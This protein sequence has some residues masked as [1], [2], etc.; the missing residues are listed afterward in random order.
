MEPTIIG[1]RLASAAV[2]PLIK[3]L[4]VAE[5]PGAGLVDKPIRISGYVSFNGEKRVLTKTDVRHLAA[6]LVEQALRSGESPIRADEQPAVTD[7]LATTLQALGELTITDLDAVR[8]GH[9]E[10]ARELRRASDNPERHL[11]ADGAYFY[12]TLLSTACLHILHFFTQRS[13]FVAHTL[14]QQ[15]RAVD[16]LIGKMDELIRRNPLPGGEDAAFEQGYLEYVAKK[17]GKLTI[18]GIDLNNSPTRWSLDVAYLSLEASPLYG[19]WRSDARLRTL[20]QHGTLQDGVAGFRLSGSANRAIR[21]AAEREISWSAGMDHDEEAWSRIAQ[22][23]VELSESSSEHWATRNSLNLIIHRDAAAV[24]GILNLLAPQAADQALATHPR[25]LLRG[26]AGSGKTTLIQWL[27]VTTA[28]QDLPDRKEYLYDRVP[29]V[30]PLRTLTR[31]GER[32]PGPRDFLSATGCPLAGS[33]PD[34]WEHRVLVAGRGLVLID[35]ID[36]IPERERERTRRWLQ[37]LIETYDGDNR[38]LVTSRPSAVDQGWLDEDDFAELTL[39]A[40]GPADI[41]T[42]IKRWHDAARASAD[43][44][45]DL[46]KYEAQL[47]TAVRTEPDLGRLAINP[48]M[49]GLICALHRDRRGYLPHGRKDLY[50]AALSMLLSRRDRERDM[51]G[52]E[53]ADD[54]QLDVLQRLAYWLI[55]NGRN[56]MDRSRAEDIIGRAL[57]AVPEMA[58]LGDAST[59]FEH[60][61]QRSGLLR[62]PAPDSVEFIHRTFQDFLGARAALEEGDF[63]LLVEH[64]ANDQW[65]D[66]IRMAVALARGRE[67]VTIFQDLLDRGD[68]AEDNRVQARIYL[69]AAAC[70]GHATSLLPAVRQEVEQ[71]TATLIPPGNEEEARALADVGPLILNLLPG[72][73]E[74]SDDVAAFHVVIAASHIKADAAIDFLARFVE[75]PSLPV[76][77]Q[78]LWA[79]PRFETAEYAERVIARL[80]PSNLTYTVQSD[81]QL[82]Q[83]NR[84]GLR[85]EGLDVRAGVSPEALASYVSRHG[86]A[87]LVLSNGATSDLGFLSGRTE[88]RSLIISGC[89]ALMDLSAIRGLPI[90]HFDVTSTRPDMDLSP[91][92]EL[93]DLKSLVLSGP[94]G[95]K[96]APQA[97]PVRAPLNSL[98]VS[99]GASPTRG[100]KGL[101]DSSLLMSLTLNPLSSPASA[102]D[103]EEISR[104]SH[105]TDFSTIAASFETLP[106]ATVLESVSNLSLAGGGGERVIQAAVNRLP[107]TFPGLIYCEFTGDMTAEGDIDVTPL[108]KLPYLQSLYIAIGS[109]RIRGA[110]ALP[111]SVDLRLL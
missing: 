62:E 111:S 76:R 17:H 43:D 8:L 12:E 77:S 52:P 55:K 49:C 11:T 80:D 2:G 16:E 3:K 61:L 105:L 103:W 79:W 63:G 75:H 19:R 38:W 42:F 56:E 109:D 46:D 37:D 47:L 40:M 25:L 73:E 107:A 60:F 65:E 14:I 57:P 1:T 84:L 35:G 29:F 27:A 94:S 108:A 4:F 68:R 110:Q 71:R 39:S 26:E 33:Q 90:Q 53:L 45:A 74:L 101:A 93:P 100:L 102:D 91:V 78:L 20:L 34:G 64:A 44:V 89:L 104:L 32:L 36:E 23:V 51:A 13:T 7:A 54:P 88:L 15:A 66:V 82:Q 31:H 70:L 10:F 18:Y 22:Q 85:P 81:D 41:A 99:G 21:K 92:S 9:Q 67:R 98:R 24:R 58:A 69:L 6:K 5:G 86:V 83:L 87:F 96:W 59:V 50:E 48:L 30:L 97:L 95:F 72:P 28:R 106:T